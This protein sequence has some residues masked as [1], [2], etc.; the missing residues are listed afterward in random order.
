MFD[1]NFINISYVHQRSIFDT[2]CPYFSATDLNEIPKKYS[3][4]SR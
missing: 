4:S 1:I 2:K 3:I